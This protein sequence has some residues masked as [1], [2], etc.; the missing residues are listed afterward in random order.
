MSDPQQEESIEQQQAMMRPYAEA[1]GYRIIREYQDEG[2][3]GD[4]T[5]KRRGFLQMR[6]DATR[7]HDFEAILV[8]DQDRFG[9]FDSLEAGYWIKPL[10]DAG[11][12]LVTFKDGAIDWN[13]F[14]KR[15]VYTITQEG[16]HQFLRDIS[17]NIT[18]GMLANARA[19][20]RNGAYVPYAYDRMLVDEEGQPR[21]RLRVGEKVARPKSWSFTLVPSDEPGEVETVVWVFRTFL[22]T[23]TSLRAI[24]NDLNSRGVPAPGRHHRRGDRERPLWDTNAIK[25]LLTNP[26]Y[27]GDYRWGQVGSGSYHRVVNG[28]VAETKGKRRRHANDQPAIYARDIFPPLVTRET[29]EQVQA[30]FAERKV[31]HTYVRDAGY[32]L[33]G[34]LYCGH[35]GGR[36]HGTRTGCRAHGKVYAY[37]RYVCKSNTA[38]GS[39][40]CARHS[41]REDRLLPFLV[42]RLRADYLA[43]ERLEQLEAELRRRLEIR[44]RGL[45]RCDTDRLRQRLAEV[46]EQVKQAT[47]NV[48]RAKSNI[49]LL[50]EALTT[51]RAE[52]DQL[53]DE[54]HD[55]EARQEPEIDTEAAVEKAVARL[56]TLGERLGDADPRR[57]RE[58]MRQMVARIDL[59]YETTPGRKWRSPF[60]L[61]RGVV[62]FRPQV[63]FEGCAPSGPRSGAPRSAS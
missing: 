59:F 35:C 27:C 5:D 20:R 8:W 3:S 56:R 24:A 9:R 6:E 58:V 34:L 42:R 7:L 19:G 10:R 21:Q 61:E 26:V 63:P 41:I 47:L 17:R 49:D 30:K 53:A 51:L 54:L 55:A 22:D 40:V 28:E 50:N 25:R 14:T 44:R 52:R 13:D 32:P 48:L 62:K 60:R 11:I 18:R 39:A 33:T 4:K 29:W 1:H 12:V 2:I 36:M 23:D 37:R 46:D 38:H 57:L 31:S 43:P 45:T 16:K 15:L